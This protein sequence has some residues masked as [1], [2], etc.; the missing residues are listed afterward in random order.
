MKSCAL[1][2]VS[3]VVKGSRVNT[4]SRVC[5]LSFAAD[6][7]SQRAKRSWSDPG[8]RTPTLLQRCHEVVSNKFFNDMRILQLKFLINKRRNEAA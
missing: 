4:L 2:L 7:P 6:V 8:A 5:L 3:L 1:Q